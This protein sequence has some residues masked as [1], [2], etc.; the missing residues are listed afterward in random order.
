MNRIGWCTFVC[1][2]IICFSVGTNAKTAVWQDLLV[3][4]CNKGL[5]ILPSSPLGISVDATPVLTFLDFGL[6]EVKKRIACNDKTKATKDHALCRY[7]PSIEMAMY[8]F[9]QAYNDTDAQ[10]M[11]D[12]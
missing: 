8:N 2:T 12:A 5:H 4:D 3:H 9:A 10:E 11:S 7:I 1:A 6:K